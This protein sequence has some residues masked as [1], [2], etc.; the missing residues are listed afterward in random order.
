MVAAYP[1]GKYLGENFDHRLA[2]RR[3]GIAGGR[4]RVPDGHVGHDAGRQALGFRIFEQRF[5]LG[6]VHAIFP[7]ENGQHA[8]V[9][10]FAGHDRR[11]AGG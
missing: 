9:G 11:H 10:F 7:G 1:W 4:G 6:S 2:G 8:V 5:Q 3:M